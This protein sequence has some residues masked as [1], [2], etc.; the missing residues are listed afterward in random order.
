MT[1]KLLGLLLC[2]GTLMI[3]Q[4][5]SASQTDYTSGELVSSEQH[6]PLNKKNNL[7]L[8]KLFKFN[9][10]AVKVD[11]NTAKL[12]PNLQSKAGAI[13]GKA[14][15]NM[16]KDFSLD[17]D[18]NLGSDSNGADGIGIVFH[19]GDIGQLGSYG[20]GLGIL[21]LPN[22]IGFEL[23]TFWSAPADND[24]SYGHDQMLGAHAGFV[25]TDTAN[26]ILTALA[27]M[28]YISSPNNTY[29]NL[30]INWSSGK[31]ILTADYEGKHWEI[32]PKVDKS[33]TYTFEI[34]ASTG[35][36]FN[37]HKVQLKNFQAAFTP[38]LKASDISIVAG[39]Q[40]DPFDPQIGLEA[41]DPIDGDITNKIKVKSNNVNTSVP[42]DYQVV[43][44]VTNSGGEAA[45]KT[46]DV[47]V[48]A[49]TPTISANDISIG[50]DSKFDPFDP[51]IG[52]K[53]VD[54]IDGDITNK[55]KVKSNNVDTSVP[56]DYQVVYEVTN[57]LGGTSTKNINVTVSLEPTWPDGAP[58]GWKN[59]AGEELEL[60]NDPDNALF[61][62]Y[63]FYSEQQAAIYKTFE[64]DEAFQEGKYRVTVYAKG[65]NDTRPSLP[66]KVSLK[67]D[68][69]GTDSRTLLLANPLS[70]GELGDKGYYKVSADVDIAADE[71]TP[72]ITVENYQGG[73]ISG[74]FI[75]PIK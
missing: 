27:P 12:T 65:K 70:G 64:G 17:I 67:K 34:A 8:V 57:S 56:G 11:D 6:T 29:N 72:L 13:S 33:S 2:T 10:S 25:S 3:P 54:P 61:G 20:G 32:S 59:F 7:S 47:T 68:P 73:Y 9:G 55:I 74:I 60:L 63:V 26:E 62:D 1:K 44:E 53:A 19:K 31:N 41:S 50:R 37:E 14:G 30:K 49:P 45:T 43:Y 52:L 42:G 23:D 28:Q 21:G 24:P 48:K 51:K 69:S 71:T 35:Q 66:L 36:K 15:I 75:E 5:V 39:N 18:V 58:N 4:L 46:I 22:G 40:F 38:E 16:N